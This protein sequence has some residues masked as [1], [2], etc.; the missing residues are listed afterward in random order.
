MKANPH[1]TN[2][3]HGMRYS[4]EYSSWNAMLNRCR[5]E[6]SKDYHKYGAVGVTV[7]PELTS[8]EAFF[9]HI[10]PRPPGCTLDR[11]EN[12]KGYEIGNIRW[13]TP[14]EQAR[15]RRTSKIWCVKGLQFE[16]AQQAADHFGVSDVT[17]HR[18]VKGFYDARRGTSQPALENCNVISRS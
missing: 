10:G 17:I 13:A 11:I 14:G 12:D 4:K 16:S 7:S 6:K 2:L 3:K 18:W 9:A 15:N 8:F 5:N 1:V